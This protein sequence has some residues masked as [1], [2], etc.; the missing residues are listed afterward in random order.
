[1]AILLWDLVQNAL[2]SKQAIWW[3]IKYSN[4]TLMANWHELKKQKKCSPL[5]PP[6]SILYQTQWAWQGVKL[7]RNLIDVNFHLLISL[8]SFFSWKNLV[9]KRTRGLKVPFL[10]PLRVRDKKERCLL[11][12]PAFAKY[13]IGNVAKTYV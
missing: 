8:E 5:A 13:V 12:H 6:R 2:K 7:T 9:Q 1:M 11:M 10:M 3:F 4:L